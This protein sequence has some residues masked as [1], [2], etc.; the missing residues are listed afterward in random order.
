[1]FHFFLVTSVTYLIPAWGIARTTVGIAPVMTR[2]AQVNGNARLYQ[3]NF[4]DLRAEE[5]PENVFGYV[6]PFAVSGALVVHILKHL[7]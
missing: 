5:P 6:E 1:M 3:A 2:M 4:S 7:K